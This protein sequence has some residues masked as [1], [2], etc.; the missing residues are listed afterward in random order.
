MK[1][2]YDIPTD[3]TL[4]AMTENGS[5]GF[6][7]A[8]YYDEIDRYRLKCVNWHWHREFE[9]TVVTN[10]PVV[11]DVGMQSVTLQPGQGLFINCGEIH[12]FSGQGGTLRDVLFAP[13][14]IAPPDSAIFQKYIAPV[15]NASMKCRVLHPGSAASLFACFDELYS[16]AQRPMQELYTHRVAC[17][18]W[19]ELF[20]L[21]QPELTETEPASDRLVRARMQLML[22]FIRQNYQQSINLDDIAD[23]AQISKSEAFRCFRK[24]IQS[25][26]G[27]YLTEY[28]LERAKEMLTTTDDTVTIVAKHTGFQSAGYFCRVF[29]SRFGMTP[30]SYRKSE[31]SIS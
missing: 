20:P 5:Q 28:R 11:C 10:G 31:T 3:E 25:T 26:P 22:E 6:P 24:G 13:E 17:Q 1:Q 9:F 15:A 27:K 7:F 29:K 8:V 19:E 21:I 2:L 16:S 12:R 4:R 18:M 30:E 23:S 14:F